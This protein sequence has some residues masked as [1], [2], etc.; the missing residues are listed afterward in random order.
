[1]FLFPKMAWR[2]IIRNMRRTLITLAAI[3]FGLASVIIFFGFTDGFHAQWI[4]NSVKVYS[5]H[6]LVYAAGYREENNLNRNIKD[7]G[8]VEKW[9]SDLPSVH[10]FTTRIHIPGLISTA[11]SSRSISIR[12]IDPEKEKGITALDKRMIEGEYLNKDDKADILLGHTLAEKL[13]ARIGDKVVLMVQAADGSIGAELFR[14]KG[15]FRIGAVDLD[16]FLAIITLRDAQALAVL[17]NSVTEAVLIVDQPG[18]VLPTARRLKSKLG[19]QGYEVISWQEYM[20]QAKEMIDLSSAFM[21]VILVIVLI[22]VSLGILNTMLMSIMERTR[23]LGIMMALGTKPR[24]VVALVMLESL[25]LG[26]IG[27]ILGMGIGIGANWLIAL[28]GFDL[29]GWSGAMDLVASLHP[30]IYP[31]TNVANVCLATATTFLTTLLVSVYPALKAAGLK[32]VEAIHF[33]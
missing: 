4:E 31:D 18:N 28:K 25:F 10:T 15:I 8:L 11:E 30:V 32:P 12:G 22:V 2:N 17:G 16:R 7:V 27:I 14:L 1:M 26:L 23:E 24:Q 5:G 19:P 21:Y 13:N 20:P 3:A 29:S 9:V 33:V 6:I